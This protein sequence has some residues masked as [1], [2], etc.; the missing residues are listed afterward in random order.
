MDWLLVVIGGI[1]LIG[2]GIGVYRGAIRIAVSLVTTI[3]TIIVVVFATPHVAKLIS[4]KTPLDDMIISQVSK[5][6]ANA[7]T[8]QVLDGDGDTANVSEEDVRKVLEAAGITE[9]QLA[10]YGIS[11][12]DIV[13]GNISGDELAQYGISS[14][15]LDGLRNSGTVEKAIEEAEIPRDVQMAAIE[16]AELPEIFKELL[17][18]NNNSEIYNELGAETFAQYVGRFLAKLIINIIAFLAVFILLTIVLRAVIFAL[19]VVSNLP[20]LGFV[21]RLAGGGTGL[22][23]ALVVVWVLFIIITLL[24]TTSFGKEMYDVILGND[25]TKMIYE[26]NPIMKLA[27]NFK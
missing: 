14:S 13:N 4:D 12:S 26:N 23:C 21:N 3:V 9:E 24:Y 11:V 19:D 18:T 7:A 25:I 15:L 20:V 5:T 10:Q 27:V 17:S 8:S 6:M 1:F 2:F 22:L 16:K